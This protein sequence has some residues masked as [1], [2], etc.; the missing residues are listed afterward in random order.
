MPEEL[1]PVRRV[2]PGGI[3]PR[4]VWCDGE[5]YMRAVLD[6][7]TRRCPCTA[8]HGCGRY[9]PESYVRYQPEGED[10]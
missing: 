2:A 9:L 1:G 8:A 3:Y 10:A 7:S 5:Q 6:Y 4:C